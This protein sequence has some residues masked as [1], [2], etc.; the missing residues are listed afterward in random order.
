MDEAT[1]LLLTLEFTDPRAP[2]ACAGWTAHELVAHLAAGAA[3]MAGH[4]E[5]ALVGE[6]EQ[7]ARGFA[8]REAPFVAMEDPELRDRLFTEALR[9]HAAVDALSERGLSVAF[10]GRRLSAREIR[11]HGRSEAAL[12][13]WDLCG[14]D[15]IG[16]QHLGPPELT[17]HAVTVLN[18]LAAEVV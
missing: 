9:L 16:V 18:S 10:S 3:E 5:R 2:T 1:A 17:T 4:A 8:E 6:P 14:D 11:T 7:A 15:E 12:H 13:R